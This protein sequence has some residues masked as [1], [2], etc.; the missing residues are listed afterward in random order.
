[1]KTFKYKLKGNF[2]KHIDMICETIKVTETKEK[3]DLNEKFKN[4]FSGEDLVYDKMRK[5]GLLYML[6]KK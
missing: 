3:C 4:G 5:Y 1:M 6:E 2:N